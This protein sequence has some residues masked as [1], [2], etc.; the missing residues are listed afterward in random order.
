MTPHLVAVTPSAYPF[1]SDLCAS[2]NV[3]RHVRT[4]GEPS[5]TAE[6][7]DKDSALNRTAGL[8]SQKRL[9][10]HRPGREDAVEGDESSPQPR[11]PG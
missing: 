4:Y 8:M 1:P 7:A 5:M 6:L 9:R 2:Y 3:E 10:G 11:R